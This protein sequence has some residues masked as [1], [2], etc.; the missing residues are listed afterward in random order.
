PRRLPEDAGAG[1][2]RQQVEAEAGP[3]RHALP[4]EGASGGGDGEEP[5]VP[6]GRKEDAPEGESEIGPRRQRPAESLGGGRP[7]APASEGQPGR[8]RGAAEPRGDA[9][10]AGQGGLRR[11]Q[12]D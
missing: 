5:G 7:Q 6:P 3:Q 2:E 9:E 4:P 1:G 8:Q 12:P 10:G 11:S